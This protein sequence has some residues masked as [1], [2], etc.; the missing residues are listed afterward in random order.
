MKAKV[1]IIDA[2]TITNRGNVLSVSIESG[3][4]ESGDLLVV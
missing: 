1:K 3:T 4:L 2:F